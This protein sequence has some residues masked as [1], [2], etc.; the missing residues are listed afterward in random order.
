[1]ASTYLKTKDYR[2]TLT[3]TVNVEGMRLSRTET[4]TAKGEILN[5]I[6]EQDG[7]DAIDSAERL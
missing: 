1:M 3:K 6:E 4:H 7:A 5:K 2:F